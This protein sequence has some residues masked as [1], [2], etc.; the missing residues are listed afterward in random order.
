MRLAYTVLW[1]TFVLALVV[2][3]VVAA[4]LYW[5]DVQRKP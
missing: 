1:I 5:R 3:F 4:V 2:Y